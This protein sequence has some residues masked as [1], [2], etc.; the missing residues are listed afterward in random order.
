MRNST[1][2]W[3]PVYLTHCRGAPAMKSKLLHKKGYCLDKSDALLDGQ[4]ENIEDSSEP[5]EAARHRT[6]R[7]TWLLTPRP[8]RKHSLGSGA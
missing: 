4:Q 2:I 5:F 3:F 6:I 1:L 7:S 8:L